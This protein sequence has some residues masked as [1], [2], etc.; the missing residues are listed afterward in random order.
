[1]RLSLKHLNWASKFPRGTRPLGIGG[2]VMAVITPIAL[3]APIAIYSTGYGL[4]PGQLDPNYTL[5]VNALGNGTST[6]VAEGEPPTNWPLNGTWATNPPAAWIA[7]EAN[8]VDVPG[9]GSDTQYVYTTTFDLLTG[10]DPATA[11]LTGY[12]TADNFIA[13]VQLNGHTVYNSSSCM[14]PSPQ[15]GYFFQNLYPFDIGSD[16][17]SGINTLSF[18]VTN[19]NCFNTPPMTNPTGLL[20]DIS[21]TVDPTGTVVAPLGSIPEPGTLFCTAFGLML[22]IYRVTLRDRS[23]A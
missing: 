11:N 23:R 5:T 7:P 18:M 3:A 6:Y 14:S 22:L 9:T 4:A 10:F 15:G 13:Q 2:L 21:G 12:W 20:V 19:S 17:Q 1:M 16:F 8:V